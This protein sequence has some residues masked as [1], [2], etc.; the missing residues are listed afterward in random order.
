MKLSLSLQDNLLLS[1]T[2]N[3]LL[4][5]GIVWKCQSFKD[6][7]I[8]IYSILFITS[9]YMKGSCFPY[10][11]PVRKCILG[12]ILLRYIHLLFPTIP[13]NKCIINIMEPILLFYFIEDWSFVC[14]CS[15]RKNW[16]YLGWMG[17]Q[18]QYYLSVHKT[19]CPASE[20]WLSTQNKKM[21]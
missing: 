21:L 17:S 6:S 4:V 15:L 18:Q 10:S 9:L 12:R 3:T 14:S 5:M 11:F 16:S 7:M 20:M 8:H 19:M 2:I 13:N 1:R